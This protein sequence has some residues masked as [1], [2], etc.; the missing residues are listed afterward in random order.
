MLDKVDEMIIG[1]GMAFTFLKVLNNME[2]RRV[3]VGVALSFTQ[4][5][6]ETFVSLCL[7]LPQRPARAVERHSSNGCETTLF[8]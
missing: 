3:R 6:C 5:T 2:V 8:S 1:G 7:R 4:L